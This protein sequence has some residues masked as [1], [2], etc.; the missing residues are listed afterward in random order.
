MLEIKVSVDLRGGDVGVAEQLLHAAKFST[1][2]KEMRGERVPEQVR[3]HV[4][5]EPLLAGPVRDPDCTPQRPQ[6]PAV[7]CPRTSA[8]SSG[9]ARLARSCFQAARASRA[10][11]PTGTMRALLPL[12]I[13]V[14]RV[15]RR[16]DPS[17]SDPTSS[18]RR[19]PEEYSSSM[20][21]R[22]R[23][24]NASPGGISSSLRHLIRIERHRES[25]VSRFGCARSSSG[26]VRRC[27][28]G[29]SSADVAFRR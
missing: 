22:S 27:T 13:D 28:S 23:A 14:D 20:I 10:L 15:V 17:G 2:F 25:R 19:R 29:A 9:F 26:R 24:L 4:L 12:P 6:S 1:G 3:V 8:S 16:A 18:A 7:A 5:L 21:A 11:L